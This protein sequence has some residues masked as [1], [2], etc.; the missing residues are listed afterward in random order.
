MA[1]R[2]PST[3]PCPFAQSTV[4]IVGDLLDDLHDVAEVR[5]LRSV[6]LA[7]VERRSDRDVARLGKAAAE[8]LDVLV[9]T[10]D[11]LHDEHHR[12]L[13]VAF[14]HG[15]V[16]RHLADLHLT[17]DQA[18]F[19]RVD[20]LG[21]DRANGERE[22][23]AQG[24]DDERATTEVFQLHGS[25]NLSRSDRRRARR[26]ARDHASRRESRTRRAD[27]RGIRRARPVGGWWR[28]SRRRSPR[29]PPFRARRP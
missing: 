19:V 22:A 14:R 17:R 24:R 11:L 5:H 9:Y 23:R 21:V 13:A 12:K 29:S 26:T 7:R 6:A 15:A 20:R 27:R 3:F 25:I 8:V 16:G 2:S 4:L 28:A 1:T 18:L 10:E